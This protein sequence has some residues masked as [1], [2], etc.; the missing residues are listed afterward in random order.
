[1]FLATVLDLWSRRMVGFATSNDYPTAELA[2]AAI[3][4]AVA[5][6]GGKTKGVIF[7]SDKG[8]QYTSEAFAAACRRLGIARS[9]GRTGN[10]PA[11]S[12]F[13]TLQHEL[14][15]RRFWATKAQAH[16][17]GSTAGT[18]SAA[19]TPPPEWSHR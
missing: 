11:E 6:R 18:T 9:S 10:A 16:R 4:T 7:H 17:Y 2:K 15:D 14:I 12:F 3:N 1:M 13:S 5:T 8:S 19:S